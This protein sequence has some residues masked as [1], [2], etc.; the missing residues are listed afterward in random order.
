MIVSNTNYDRLPTQLTNDLLRIERRATDYL[1]T[2]DNQSNISI[3]S[4]NSIISIIVG[5]LLMK[6]PVNSSI[7]LSTKQKP[8]YSTVSSQSI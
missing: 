1:F 8:N 6:V 4:I 7:G 3:V 5:E 2:P